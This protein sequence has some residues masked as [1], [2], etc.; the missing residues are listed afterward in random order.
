VRTSKPG[1]GPVDL[2]PVSPSSAFPD[3]ATAWVFDW[4]AMNR[5]MLV[6]G[7]CSGRW[8]GKQRQ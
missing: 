8:A 5:G 6:E 7:A 1:N 2:S 4:L 3:C